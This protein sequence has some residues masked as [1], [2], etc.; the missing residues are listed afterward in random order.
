MASITIPFTATSAR[1]IKVVAK[2][3]GVIGE[4]KPGSGSKAWLFVD[5]IGVN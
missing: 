1:F 5:E 3:H 4:G 2:N